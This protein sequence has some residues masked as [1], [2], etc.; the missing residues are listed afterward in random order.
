MGWGVRLMHTGFLTNLPVCVFYVCVCVFLH[1]Y[2]RKYLPVLL[3][4]LWWNSVWH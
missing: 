4:M 2:V 3:C 1:K